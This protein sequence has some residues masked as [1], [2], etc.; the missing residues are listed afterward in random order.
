[1]T[2]PP[3][4]A[5]IAVGK[6]AMEGKAVDETTL[7][8]LD[9]ICRRWLDQPLE[10][11]PPERI[12][13]EDAWNAVAG[14]IRGLRTTPAAALDPDAEP[15]VRQAVLD[16]AVTGDANALDGLPDSAFTLLR[17]YLT[18]IMECYTFRGLAGADNDILVPELHHATAQAEALIAIEILSSRT[19][20]RWLAEF[21][22]E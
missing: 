16:F 8:A 2:P 21:P 18:A 14:L 15:L 5:I 22:R 6:H 7:F 19:P 20:Q 9:G 17:A 3:G 11:T 1:M 13:Y 10:E 4:S 12:S